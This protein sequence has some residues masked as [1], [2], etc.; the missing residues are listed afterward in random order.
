[1]ESRQSGNGVCRRWREV[2]QATHIE[3]P[4]IEFMVQFVKFGTERH[5][6][7]QCEVK[8]LAKTTAGALKI[9]RSQVRR[10]EKFAV[11]SQQARLTAPV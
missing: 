11:V 10:A 2:L 6:A 9:C 7:H 8:V 5:P 4:E 1:M 3:P